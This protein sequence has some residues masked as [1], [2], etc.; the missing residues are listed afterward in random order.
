MKQAAKKSEVAR[1]QLSKDKQSGK[2]HLASGDDVDPYAGYAPAMSE[3]NGSH[4]VP[5]HHDVRSLLRLYV[6]NGMH[7]PYL[8][9]KIRCRRRPVH[10]LRQANL[11]CSSLLRPVQ[12]TWQKHLTHA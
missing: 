6:R 12:S 4:A 9:V 8:L 2:A 1:K 10:V 3:P 5:L 11:K 7:M